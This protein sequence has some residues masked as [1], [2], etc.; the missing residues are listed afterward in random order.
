LA[1]GKF[2]AKPVSIQAIFL[3]GF[4]ESSSMHE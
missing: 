1:E 3:C 4:A 2:G